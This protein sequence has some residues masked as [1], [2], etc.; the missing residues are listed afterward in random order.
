MAVLSGIVP[1]FLL[2]ALGALA[3][4]L[5]W[6]GEV[7]VRDLNRVIFWFA[8]PALLVRLLGRA[9]LV[10]TDAGTMIGTVIAATAGTGLVAFLYA[11]MRRERP[12]RLGVI[13][14]AAVRGN[15]V[16]VGFPVIF[17]A[18]GESALTLA[19]VTAAILIPF[20]NLLAVAGLLRAGD[21]RGLGAFK[22]AV[23]NPVVLGVAGG[24]VCNWIGWAPWAWLDNFLH[25]LGNIAMPGALLALG[26]QMG[27]RTLRRSTEAVAVSTVLKLALAPAIGLILMHLFQVDGM[28]RLV[29]IFLLATP[30]AIASTAVAQEMGGDLDLAGACVMI[31]SLAS[32]PAYIIWGLI[33]Q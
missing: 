16:F 20:Q 12:A 17:A 32:F 6:A 19:A 26:A 23:L 28:P 27:A 24:L 8:I 3:K 13:V 33:C 29:G 9:E 7:F 1:V 15:L 2:I 18:G 21:H 31:A 22:A 4:R 10:A 14:Q 5:G 30:T 25:L 11:L